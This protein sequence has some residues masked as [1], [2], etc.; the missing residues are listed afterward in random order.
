MLGSM[1]N[2]SRQTRF[3]SMPDV[4]NLVK[5]I[6]IGAAV[7]GILQLAVGIYFVQLAG[8]V[9]TA[10]AGSPMPFGVMS[11]LMAFL[12]FAATWGFPRRIRRL[13]APVLAWN[14][15]VGLMLITLLFSDYWVWFLLLEVLVLGIPI[16]L[17]I[18]H[19][20]AWVRREV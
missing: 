5:V 1:P 18:P 4:P 8:S 11:I 2:E 12:M 3:W 19:V 14:L 10:T 20:R 13:W 15:T 9:D 6:S 7:Q 17:V 16:C